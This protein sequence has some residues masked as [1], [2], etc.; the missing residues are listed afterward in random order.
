MKRL[1]QAVTC[2]A[3]LWAATTTTASAGGGCSELP[4]SGAELARRADWAVQIYQEL[5]ARNPE[6]ALLARVGS[7]VSEYGLRYTHIGLV[8]REHPKGRWGM[9]HMLNTCGLDTAH[10]FDQ[11]LLNFLLDDPLALDILMLELKPELQ[12]AIVERIKAGAG[13]Q[14]RHPDYSTVAY[15]FSTRYQNSNQW[16]LEII[17]AAEA[18]LAG[19]PVRNRRDAQQILSAHG[20]RGSIIHLSGFKQSMAKIS[21]ANIH[22]DDHPA[23]ARRRGNFEA[24]TV[25][26]IK[27]YLARN[28]HLTNASEFIYPHSELFERRM[29]VV[30]Q[31]EEDQ[32]FYS[33]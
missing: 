3:I 18:D 4:M 31:Q 23:Q 5:D 33:P 15:P 14:F 8:W 22:F 11:G 9:V 32:T 7:D 29:A 19:E 30:E 12:R 28:G 21:R 24:V 13:N 6:L 20:Y 26:S 16:L 2:A 25:K 27:Q 10:I 1:A 17:G